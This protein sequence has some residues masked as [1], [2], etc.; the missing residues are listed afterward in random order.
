MFCRDN[1][2]EP[3]R[4]R[5]A[6]SRASSRVQ[7]RVGTDGRTRQSLS[8][9]PSPKQTSER[10]A[11]RSFLALLYFLDVFGL[12]ASNVPLLRGTATYLFFFTS[13]FR[14]RSTL[15]KYDATHWRLCVQRRYLTVYREH[16]DDDDGATPT[17][18]CLV[19]TSYTLTTTT[20]KTTPFTTDLFALTA[21]STSS[22]S[23]SR[24]R[25]FRRENERERERE[26]KSERR[27]C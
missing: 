5:E 18:Y 8:L 3:A 22:S 13:A 1:C 19:V 16:E 23:S 17:H 27:Y 7:P 4:P 9:P 15:L 24:K 11:K 20:T 12:S 21:S 26:R 2:S 10:F 14:T 25:Q 6:S